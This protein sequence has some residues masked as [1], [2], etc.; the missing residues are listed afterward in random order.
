MQSLTEWRNFNQVPGDRKFWSG[1]RVCNP[2]W[3]RKHIS[4]IIK[5]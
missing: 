3:I 2:I 5:L 4:D 1:G